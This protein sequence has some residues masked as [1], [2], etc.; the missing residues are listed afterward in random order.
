[1]LACVH[2][3]WWVV[4]I[5]YMILGILLDVCLLSLKK[6]LP[7]AFDSDDSYFLCSI[8]SSCHFAVVSQMFGFFSPS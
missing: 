1:M 7:T 5:C 4:A 3:E 2:F 8:L 6:Y